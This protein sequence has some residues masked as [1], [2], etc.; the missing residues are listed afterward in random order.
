M[1]NKK[2]S[3]DVIVVGAGTGGSTAARMLAQ[4]GVD[5]CLIDRKDEKKV[6]DKICGDVVGTEI[7][8][9]L[10][11]TPPK[12]AEL[13]CHIKGSKLYPPNRE[14]CI[15]LTDPKQA[16][17]IV[18]RLEFGQRL[19]N[20]AIDAGVKEFLDHTMALELLYIDKTVSGLN[21]RLKNGEKKE[22]T[23]K[24]VIDAGGFYS[25]LKK[26]VKSSLVEKEI[27]EEDIILCYREI[28]SFQD[29]SQSV[30][31]PEYITII[32]DQEKAPGGY[33]WYFPRN[34]YSV[35]M[36][37]GVYANYGGKVKDIYQNNVFR[38]FI[39][40]DK[41]RINSTGGGAVPARRPLWSCVDNGLLLIGD[42]ACHVNPLHG[43]GIDPSMRAGYFASLTALNAFDKGDFTSNVLWDYNSKIMTTFGAE[44][45]AL[46]LL[47]IALQKLSNSKLNFGFSKDLLTSSEILEV[48]SSGCIQLG[49]MDLAFKAIKGISKPKLLLDLN[50]LRIQMNKI[51]KHYKT[52]PNKA[53]DFEKWKVK[54][55]QIYD[56][57][58]KSTF[59]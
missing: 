32:L 26:Q 27:A 38:Q 5:V 40:S 29:H 18:N 7:F 51:Y 17:Y 12:D 42:A 36:G 25:P 14:K 56:K 10:G 20:E 19:L 16:G 11:I 24:L 55:V 15:T 35:N 28:I 2:R 34:E 54:T 23:S 53:E 22:L 45:A 13:S 1:E 44:F 8:N 4:K 52:F 31:D 39:K 21:V 49:L 33:I 48:S 47:R 41:I 30:M 6:G 59:G 9:L 58:K 46:H 57:I 50:Y 43:G 3:F 37:L